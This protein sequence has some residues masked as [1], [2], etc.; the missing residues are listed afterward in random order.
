M[1]RLMALGMTA[2]V[3]VGMTGC[4]KSSPV[5]TVSSTP[6]LTSSEASTPTSDTPTTSEEAAPT[7]DA[8]TS[9]SGSSVAIDQSTPEAALKS[10]VTSMVKGDLKSA[11]KVLSANGMSFDTNDAALS[12]CESSMG[13]SLGSQDLSILGSFSVTGATITGDK[14]SFKNAKFTPLGAESIGSMFSAVR[15]NGKWYITVGS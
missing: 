1:K 3:A 2:A 15:I 9:D 10:V 12:A 8:P 5:P 13:N 7:S 14:A 6:V 4:S 11:C